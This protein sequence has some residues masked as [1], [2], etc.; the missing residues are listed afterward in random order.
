M[1]TVRGWARAGCFGDGAEAASAASIAVRAA[2]RAPL[3]S[4]RPNLTRSMK[5]I[6][7]AS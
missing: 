2:M 6:L 5:K 1:V 4:T 3:P 7:R